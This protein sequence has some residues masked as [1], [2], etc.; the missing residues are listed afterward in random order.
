MDEVSEQLPVISPS[1]LPVPSWRDDYQFDPKFDLGI[2]EWIGEG[3]N[4]IAS[5]HGTLGAEGNSSGV[6]NKENAMRCNYI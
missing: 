3:N 5:D 6:E 4:A 1:L 2:G